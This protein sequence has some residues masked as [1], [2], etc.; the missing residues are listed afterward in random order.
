M[1]MGTSGTVET[2]DLTVCGRNL[3]WENQQRGL[4][5]PISDLKESG[6]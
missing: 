6:A 1:G 2:Y 3:Y 5:W 4:P